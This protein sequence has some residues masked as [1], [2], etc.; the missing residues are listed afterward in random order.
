MSDETDMNGAAELPTFANAAQKLSD[1]NAQDRACG[2]SIPIHTL[3]M[4]ESRIFAQ[5]KAGTLKIYVN[6]E[7]QPNGKGFE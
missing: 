4:G 1:L 2:F 7:L 6:G 5:K 3:P